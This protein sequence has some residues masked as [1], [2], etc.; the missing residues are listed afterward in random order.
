MHFL[1]IYTVPVFILEIMLCCRPHLSK[2]GMHWYIAS[3]IFVKGTV[4][5]MQLNHTA[6]WLNRGYG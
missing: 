1:Y 5:L 2:A 4:I 3:L 6:L